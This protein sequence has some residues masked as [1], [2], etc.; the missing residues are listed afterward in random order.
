VRTKQDLGVIAEELAEVLPEAV[1]RDSN[2]TPVGVDYSRLTVLSIKAIQDLREINH[3]QR[4]QLA[5]L[6]ARLERIER[7]T[8]K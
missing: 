7:S 6:E 5:D 1:T 8:T 4:K 2:G 3:L